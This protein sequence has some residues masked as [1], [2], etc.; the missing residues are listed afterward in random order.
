MH[1]GPLRGG[2]AHGSAPAIYRAVR[3][4]GHVPRHRGHSSK[5]GGDTSGLHPLMTNMIR[6]PNQN[7]IS[8]IIVLLF[9]CIPNRRPHAPGRMSARS[10]SSS[11]G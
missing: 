6:I 8:L 2:R 7:N 9:I 11:T 3:G 1:G 4:P 5:A 10:N